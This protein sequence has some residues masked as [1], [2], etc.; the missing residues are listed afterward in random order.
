[1][2][3]TGSKILRS[4]VCG[5]GMRSVLEKVGDGEGDAF[6]ELS[7]GWGE[8]PRCGVGQGIAVT[9][10]EAT[11]FLPLPRNTA[12]SCC[13]C[14]QLRDRCSRSSLDTLSSLCLW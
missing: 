10:E 8:L 4:S 14:P 3:G 13:L 1:M 7:E 11:V 12:Q 5:Q 2:V 9:A 6:D